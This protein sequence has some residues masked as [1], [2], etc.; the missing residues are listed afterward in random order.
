MEYLKNVGRENQGWGGGQL[1]LQL[2][3]RAISWRV[4]LENKVYLVLLLPLDM[5]LLV[6]L[7]SSGS[8]CFLHASSIKMSSGVNFIENA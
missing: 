3:A 8:C 5:S 6:R 7:A 2:H 1:E 4:D